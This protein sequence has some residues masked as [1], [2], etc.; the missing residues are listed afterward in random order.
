MSN[1]AKTT[2]ETFEIVVDDGMRDVPIRNTSGKQI[3]IFRFRP[4]DINLVNRYN[5]LV[6]DLD[7]IAEPLE[8]V[9][10]SADGTGEDDASM[11]ALREAEQRLFKACDTMFGGNMSEAFFGEMHPFS[12][13]NGVFYCEAA[14]ESVGKFIEKQFGQ[15]TAKINSRVKR[16]TGKYAGKV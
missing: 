3:G 14:I 1:E 4:T 10:I 15:E 8:H 9:S 13:V 2:A 7:T 12:P 11:A 6:K 16:Y 5:D